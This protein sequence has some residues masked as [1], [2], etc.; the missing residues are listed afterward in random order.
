MENATITNVNNYH[1]RVSLFVLF[2]CI[3]VPDNQQWFNNNVIAITSF[4]IVIKLLVHQVFIYYHT[5]NTLMYVI[6]LSSEIRS[7]LV[8]ICSRVGF[9][10]YSV[11]CLFLGVVE[12]ITQLA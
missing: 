12:P 3:N 8:V 11:E 6:I 9:V 7:I 1:S 2:I 5:R 4:V 10:F